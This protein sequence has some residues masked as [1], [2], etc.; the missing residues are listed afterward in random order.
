M[1]WMFMLIG[2]VLGW[3]LDESFSAALLGALLGLRDRADDSHRPLGSQSTEQQRQLEQ[4]QGC[5]AGRRATLVVLE[6]DRR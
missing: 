3:L 4:A 6:G 1:Q 2:L 5:V